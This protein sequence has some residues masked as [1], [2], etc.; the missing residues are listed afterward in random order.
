[1]ALDPAVKPPQPAR[2]PVEW[3]KAGQIRPESG[4]I[5]SN[6]AGNGRTSQIWRPGRQRADLETP[7]N[8][9]VTL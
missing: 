9:F 6:H 7:S 1:M 8:I 3:S 5:A 2:A 4:R